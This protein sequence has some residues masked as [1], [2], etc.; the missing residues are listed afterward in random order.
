MVEAPGIESSRRRTRTFR[1]RTRGAA[2]SAIRR[3]LASRT[4]AE[5]GRRGGVRGDG[6]HHVHQAGSQ[7]GA[8]D[9]AGPFVR[10][11]RANPEDAACGP[12]TAYV[13]CTGEDDRFGAG[14]T[15]GTTRAQG[16]VDS[17]RREGRRVALGLGAKAARRPRRR[18]ARGRRAGGAI[19]RRHRGCAPGGRVAARFRPARSRP[20]GQGD[21]LDRGVIIA[22]TDAL[23]DLLEGEG[24]HARVAALLRSGRLATTAVTVFEVWRG[25]ERDDARDKVRRVLR[26]VRIYPLNDIAARR[27]GE[28]H[29]ETR[30]TPI[31]ERD[32]L[33]AG[34]CLAVGRPI[35]TANVRHF[36]RVPGLQVIAAR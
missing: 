26:G 30:D 13:Q 32:T 27:A 36:R 20:R 25:L 18:R 19:R 4:L 14:G 23:I 31:G 2:K 22:D 16:Q 33:I 7:A 34:V 11:R 21:T 15:A 9:A 28:V 5:R 24:A 3:G 6:L 35:L 8:V 12:G 17:R 1:E 10:R 29:R